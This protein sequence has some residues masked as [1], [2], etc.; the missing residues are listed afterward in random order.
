MAALSPNKLSLFQISSQL[1]T[2]T[3][4]CILDFETG[5]QKQDLLKAIE[6]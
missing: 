1:T 2:L 4:F 5:K 3:F 6:A